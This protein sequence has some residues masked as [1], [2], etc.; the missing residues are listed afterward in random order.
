MADSLSFNLD[1]KVLG[2]DSSAGIVISPPP[3]VLA[4]LAANKKFPPGE[5][6]LTKAALQA[7]GGKNLGFGGDG[8]GSVTFGAHADASLIINADPSAVVGG[9]GLADPIASGLSF[10]ASPPNPPEKASSWVALLW[11]YDL[12]GA[13]RGSVG[14][15][16]GAGATFGA[17]GKK[18]GSFALL[19]RF[20]PD[21]LSR[22]VLDDLVASWR[23]PRQVSAPDDL[24]PGTW[25][26]AELD[27]SLALSIGA[28]YGYLFNWLRQVEGKLAGD[29]ALRLQLGLDATIGFTAAGR[30]ALAVSRPSPDPAQQVLRLQLFR[31]RKKGWNFAFH[32]TASVKADPGQV[33]PPTLEGL[34]RAVLNVDDGQILSD[35]QEWLDP[36]KDLGAMLAGAGADY[37]EKFLDQ[38][39]GVDVASELDQARAEL[40]GFLEKWNN[41]D[42]KVAAS[43]W[44]HI[45]EVPY[46]T[47]VRGLA[48]EV[49]D[50]LGSEQQ[51]RALITRK[52][53]SVNFFRTPE[54]Q[55]LA[56]Q[57]TDGLL[58]LI[59]S[60]QQLQQ[61]RKTADETLAIV[62]QQKVLSVAQ[63]LKAY[64]AQRFGLDKVE[65]S[66]QKAI[67]ASDP[68]K[69]DAWLRG[70]LT[71]FFDASPTVQQLNEI[72]NG[73]NAVRQK[74]QALYAKTLKALQ[75]QYEADLAM[76]YQKT[77]T[78]TALLDVEL[79]FSQDDGS[80]GTLLREA[81]AGKFNRLLTEPHGGVTLRTATL[82]HEIR[83]ERHIDLTL[84][85]SFREMGSI[86]QALAS[87]TAIDDGGR[88]LLYEVSGTD[89][90]SVATAK[91]RRDSR[92]SVTAHL[93]VQVSGQVP[94]L[95][96]HE[97]ASLTYSYS[98]H[99][100]TA[101]LRKNQLETQVGAYVQKYMSKDFPADGDGTSSGAFSI[102]VDDL[103]TEVEAL[104][105]NGTGNLG[106]TLVSLELGVPPA[107]GNAWLAAPASGSPIYLE[108]SLLLQ[109]KLKELIPFYFFQN[110]ANYGVSSSDA[111]LT[112]A[113]LPPSNWVKVKSNS[114]VP[115]GGGK[116]HWNYP[117]PEILRMMVGSSDADHN[118]Q[119][120]ILRIQGALAKVPGLAGIAERFSNPR[121][122]S[123]DIRG[124]AL[125]Q[126]LSQSL[127]SLLNVES[128]LVNA[129]AAAGAQMAKFVS[130]S[131][132]HPEQAIAALA[133]FA[134]QLTATF[135]DKVWSI[136]GRSALRPMGTL[137]FSE[138][139][140][141]IDPSLAL[142]TSALLRIAIL[143]GSVSPFP[144]ADFPDDSG[145]TPDQVLVEHMVVSA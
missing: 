9:L 128:R 24:R 117:D 77:T 56:A 14:L 5:V 121:V 29:I 112:Y 122:A 35:L 135:N 67:T 124:H 107:V 72:K 34:L 51:L 30:Y 85:S 115:A 1:K 31:Q 113:A 139:A 70:R 73:I 50:T 58:S 80:L 143:K 55:W 71:E 13:A 20:A 127:F 102:W 68:Q 118:L 137:L 99:Q 42:R 32:A 141:A 76:T 138:A 82:T 129:A 19:H 25:L 28:R 140:R 103:D 134:G 90:V 110:L 98:F 116:L 12:Q 111:L 2:A 142:D 104:E 45:E 38:V 109:A 15:G 52:I 54:G 83:R 66:L 11:S 10:P 131:A 8:S 40:S 26:I 53:E 96:R 22:D 123:A 126:P 119:M 63:K 81:L 3:E 4:A 69:L 86:N 47:A 136:Y 57:A 60:S 125:A 94:G 41:L 39:T 61:L 95:R 84:P 62:S 145:V 7:Q 78:G 64:I 49:S 37:A 21:A 18:S 133:K 16:A 91:S 132:A 89:E 46:V 88:V 48:Q 120:A 59:E 105:Q 43:L 108:M 114:L 65:A 144:P 93:P 44:A 74:G 23:L 92:L 75:R 97:A 6:V 79:D 106:N 36:T 87:V 33:A 130:Q 17:D 27:G 101:N 100:A